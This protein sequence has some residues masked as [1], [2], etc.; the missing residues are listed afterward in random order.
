MA[1]EIAPAEHRAQ[2]IQYQCCK[3]YPNSPQLYTETVFFEQKPF[4]QTPAGMPYD[5]W[6]HCFCPPPCPARPYLPIRSRKRL[7]SQAMMN[8]AT[9][10]VHFA[11]WKCT[12]KTW[13]PTKRPCGRGRSARRLRPS[14][15]PSVSRSPARTLKSSPI[16][17]L[18]RC[19]GQH[20]PVCAA[21]WR[22]QTRQVPSRPCAAGERQ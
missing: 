2:K 13:P 10:A 4:Q 21:P 20:W 16:H 3:R 15:L 6:L 18:A 14:Q 19:C 8:A 5:A 7:A 9:A 17:R 12:R 1:A 22:V 11:C